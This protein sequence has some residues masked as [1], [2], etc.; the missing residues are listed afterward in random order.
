M[1]RGRVEAG[2][3]GA[4]AR[5]ALRQRDAAAARVEVWIGG[6]DCAAALLPHLGKV[7]LDVVAHEASLG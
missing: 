1:S 3:A 5:P 7:P 2:G 6:R 4:D